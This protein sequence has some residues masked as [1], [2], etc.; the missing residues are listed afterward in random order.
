VAHDQSKQRSK[1]YIVEL[2]NDHYSTVHNLAI[3][4]VKQSWITTVFTTLWS[5]VDAFGLVWRLRPRLIICNG[6]GMGPS[7]LTPRSCASARCLRCV[8]FST[9]PADLQLML[10]LRVACR[11]MRAHMLR[12]VFLQASR[13]ARR[14]HSV[15]GELLSRA[16]PVDNGQVVI[17]YRRQVHSAVAFTSAAVSTR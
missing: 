9:I 8:Y 5:V 2:F 4:Q 1:S 13:T 11:H 6:P 15:R 3:C 12:S 17:P 14:R 7:Q 10:S 16:A